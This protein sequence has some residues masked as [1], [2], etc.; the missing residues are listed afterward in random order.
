[1]DTIRI[2]ERDNVCVNLETGHKIAVC[3]IEKGADVIKYGYPIGCATEN[4]KKGDA[5]HSHNMKTKLGDILSYEYTPSFE[6]PEAKEPFTINAYIRE[7]GDI[8]IRNDIWIIPTVGCVNSIAKQLAEKTGAICFSHPYGCSQLGDD[9]KIT[10]LILKGLIKHPNAGGVLVLGLGCENNN[11]P[12]MKKVLGSWNEDRIKFLCVQEC[13]DEIND[14]I[15]IIEQLKKKASEDKR[16]PVPS[17]R[18]KIG[19]KCGGSD[20]F[21]G[22]TANAVVGMV[23]DEICA[24]GGSAVLTEV[25]E[26]FGAETVLF[27]RCINEAVFNKSVNLINDFKQYFKNYGESVSENPSPGNKEGGITTLEEKSLGCVQKGGTA[28]VV[29][30]LDYGDTLEKSGLNLLNGP[31]NDIVCVTN[32]SAVGC[33][34]VLFT[35]GRGTPLGGAVPTIKIASNDNIAAKKPHWIDFCAYGFDK[36]SK[37]VELMKLIKA[38]A[39]GQLTKNEIYGNREIAI[40]KNGVTL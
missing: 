1:M 38:V 10:Q 7:N 25:P 32:L 29:D 12:E 33:H 4:I 2:N 21:S 6:N 3:D 30:V 28:P 18:L 40:F 15:E 27:E 31:G 9:M 26:M 8:G 13:E 24:M 5:V 34:L 16:E 22:I 19:L 37:A 17:S 14:G 11:I 35:T 20:G 36:R 39:D 23:T